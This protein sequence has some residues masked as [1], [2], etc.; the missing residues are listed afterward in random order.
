MWQ[1]DHSNKE[2]KMDEFRDLIHPVRQF[3]GASPDRLVIDL[4]QQP[5]E[6][7]EEIKCP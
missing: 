2:L 4:R 7:V 5:S 3:L 1:Q 6:G